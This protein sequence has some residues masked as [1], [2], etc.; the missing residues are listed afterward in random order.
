MRSY[1]LSPPAAAVVLFLV[2]VS[3]SAQTK[4]LRFPAIHGERV[5]FCYAGDIWTAP[6]SGGTASR[7][8]AHPGLELFPHFSPDGTWIAFTGQYDG[9]EQVYV[10]PAGG[11]APTQL[12]YYP[13]RGPLTPRWGYDNQV[14]GWTNDGKAVLFRSM[15]DHW[16]LGDTQ[17]Y[18]VSTTGG[19]P[20][21]LPMPYSGAGTFSPDGTKVCYSPLARDFRTWKRYEGGW[22][23]DL[24]IFDLK[25]FASENI[26]HHPRTDRDPM[27]I[28]N[29]IYFASDRD[30]TL[31]LY[32]YDITS[33]TTTQLTHSKT[34]DVRWPSSDAEG[35]IVYEFGGE[36]HVFDT[37]TGGD[38]AISIYVPN[39][40]VAMRPAHYPVE[41][42][43]ED[44]AL[45]PKGERA[46]F[47]A[48]GDVFTVP[49]EHGAPRNLTNSSN[50][51]DR[52]ARWSPDG[53]KVAFVSDRSGEEEL[54]LVNQDGAGTPEQLTTTLKVMLSPPVWSP[55]G[56][57]LAFSDKDGHVFALHLSDKKLTEVAKDRHGSVLD[58]AFSSHGEYLAFSLANPNNFRSLHIWSAADGK[59]H[60]ATDPDFNAFGPAWDPAGNYLYFLSDREYAPQIS[61]REFD[62]ATNRQTGIFALTLRKD[63]K[64]PFPFQ[65]DEVKT[66]STSASKVAPS[67]TDKTAETH[68]TKPVIVDFDGLAARAARVPVAADNPANLVANDGNLLYLKKPPFVYGRDPESKGTLVVFSLDDR[69]ETVLAEDTD[70]FAISADGKKVLVRQDK[71]YN[72]YDATPK[73]KDT[74]K[75]IST[76]E[77]A[78][79]R[80]PAQEW[81][82]IFAEVWRRYRDFFYVANM[83][84]YDWDA[85]KTRYQA[86]LP[87]VAHRSDLNYVL[88]EMV[89]E[90]NVGHAYI[91]DGDY[92]IPERPKVALPGA[93]FA[94]DPAAG[95]YRIAAIFPGENEEERYRS[96]LT[97]IGVD[98]KVGDYVL[99]I[100]GEE[101]KANDSPYRLLRFKADRPVELTVS[102]TP[103]RSSA[104]TVSY[105]P[106]TSETDLVYLKWVTRNRDMVAKA[107]G[108]RVGYL[109]L[110]D[111]AED[112]IREFVKW[113]YPQIRKAG[114]IVDDRANGGGNISQMVIERLS[115][116]L[117]GTGF[118]RISDDTETYPDTVFV[119]P[120]ACLL[121]ETSASDGDIF[122]YMFRQAGLGPLIGK[123]S[124]GG[125]VGIADRPPLLD[126][127]QVFVPEDATASTTGQ[128][129]IEG[130]GVDPDI[131]VE[132]DAASVIA[133]RDPQLERAIAEVL[134]ALEKRPG[135]LPARPAPPVKTP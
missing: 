46:L 55:D 80:V 87:F 23:E 62:F 109:H 91:Q 37:R 36:L 45:A 81:A 86:L 60:E 82:E 58:Y 89:A 32:K 11:G 128:W 120:M 127:G 117:L 125:V 61:T 93:R 96:P 24:F 118:D 2:A 72:L 53:R 20:Q 97:E 10:I 54:W 133:G 66:D 9:D 103:T 107:T 68:P 113:Y 5:A 111:M 56:A 119:G 70:A 41:K 31:N 99:A 6:A 104:R 57:Y 79:D 90:L 19:L 3:A 7:L 13:A 48:R 74:K 64:H 17:L 8:T 59:S 123:R 16:D 94:L 95:R 21:A 114:L 65:S 75:T 35:H 12:T 14:Y 69:K 85:L 92:E 106:I 116:K 110:P 77:L 98:V 105:R 22:A 83:H 49:V 51:H 108:G 100:D 50:A 39:D 47:V 129:V 29:A 63:V 1:R 15:Q 78:V 121:N 88:G 135:T 34:F 38:T 122:P 33:R 40:G 126:G 26:T 28:G 134:K 76:K 4:L 25:T 112:G 115:R 132:N 43:I 101:L 18:T 124:W 27:W 30:G 44:F 84:G 102:A 42:F 130:H 67:E 73:G 131:V 52:W 71:S